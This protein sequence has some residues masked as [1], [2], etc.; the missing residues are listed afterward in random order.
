MCEFCELVE[1]NNEYYIG[2]TAYW[3]I[4][5]ADDQNYPGRCIIPLKRH[6]ATMSDLTEAEWEDMRRVVKLMEGICK[7]NM[8]ATNCNWT[9]LMNG[10]YGVE[11]PNPHVHL[12]FIPRYRT[13]FETNDGLFVDETFG[14]HYVLKANFKFNRADR[15][16][17]CQMFKE[18]FEKSS[19]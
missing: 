17:I 13:P 14:D 5:L 6:C 11:K 15:A 9:C 10:A 1:K 3:K 18:D 19:L 8:H 16:R 4:Y 12:H 7:K 2:E